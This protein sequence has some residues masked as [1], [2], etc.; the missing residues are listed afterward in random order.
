MRRTVLTLAPDANTAAAVQS[1]VAVLQ[2]KASLHHVGL[3]ADDWYGGS[4]SDGF[5]QAGLPSVA[6]PRP[7]G[8][9]RPWWS[10]ADPD[11]ELCDALPTILSVFRDTASTSSSLL[12]VVD[13]RGPLEVALI[14]DAEDAGIPVVLLQHGPNIPFGFRTSPLRETLRRLA[15]PRRTSNRLRGRLLG[16]RPSGLPEILPAGHNGSY[17]ICTYSGHAHDLLAASGVP[18]GRL[19]PT[20]YPAFDRLLAFGPAEDRDLHRGLVISS[21]AG[22]FGAVDRSSAFFRLIAS[23]ARSVPGFALDLRLKRKEE[24]SLIP[25]AARRALAAAGVRIVLPEKPVPEVVGRYGVVIGDSSS[26]LLEA[27]VVGVPVVLLT[28]ADLPQ[29]DLPTLDTEIRRRLSPLALEHTDAHEEV[30]RAAIQPRYLEG[31]RGRL[32]REERYF[33]HALDGACARRVADVL[34]EVFDAA[35]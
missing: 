14:R 19:R 3:V 5:A 33:F 1:A 12:V 20:G 27:L 22:L 10:A 8:D 34:R 21:G 28:Y 25:R 35:S 32:F 26:S 23:V 16:R 7:S 18:Q 30:L 24:E 13:D 4:A 9:R 15:H 31:L 6:L 11:S 17:V 2:E 29:S